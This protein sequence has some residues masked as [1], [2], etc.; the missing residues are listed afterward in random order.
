MPTERRIKKPVKI[1]NAH[2]SVLKCAKV[3]RKA[4]VRG[5]IVKKES[6]TTPLALILFSILELK[7]VAKPPDIKNR[8]TIKPVDSR[9]KPCSFNKKGI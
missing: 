4:I 8:V 2:A 1:N 3:R 9:E 7:I 5:R 6:T